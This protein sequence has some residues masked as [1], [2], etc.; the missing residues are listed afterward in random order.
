MI[1]LTDPVSE[2]EEDFHR[3]EFYGDEGTHLATIE[4]DGIEDDKGGLWCEVAVWVRV[5]S[6]N[7]RP[8]I[9]FEKVNLLTKAGNTGAMLNRLI[10]TDAGSVNW[11]QGFTDAVGLT[12][13]AFRTQSSEGDW[14]EKGVRDGA[15]PYLLKPFILKSGVTLLFGKH[16]DGKSMLALRWGLGI[17]TGKGFG[18]ELPERTGPILYVDIEDT[19][20]PHELRMAA[21]QVSLNISDDEMSHL[22]WHERVSGNIKDARRRLKRLVRDKGFALVII[23]SVGLAR[24]G[25]VSAS[26]PTIKLF[27]LF[28]QLGV[29]VLALDHVTK[30]D[31][32]RSS[33]GNMDHREATPIG[34]QFTQS[35]AR[36]AWYIQVLPQS[37]A[38][39][40]KL[41]LFNTK[42]NHTPQHVPIGLSTKLD[43]DEHHNIT[44]VYHKVD[45]SAHD[46]IV[47]SEM[48][49]HK[50]QKLLLWHFKQQ[51]EGGHVI[52]MTLTEMT[53]GSG[54]NGSTL[55]GI[56]TEKQAMWWEQLPKSKQYILSPE[57]METAMLYDSWNLPSGTELGTNPGT[58]QEG[59]DA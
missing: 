19:K 25:D 20:E 37:T 4:F 29:P 50:H 51:R 1:P 33:T 17:A 59:K 44:E 36:L 7:D 52:P 48:Q 35:S 56:V 34:S 9:S 11:E 2:Y 14:M 38:K 39:L 47:A 32:K 12:V 6:S 42:H 26:E 28:N 40:K 57:G 3:H 23:D 43:W 46:E 22:V 54:V 8:L 30:E 41:N 55:R 13:T 18:G 27:K 5:G 58:D 45:G 15:T 53:K 16:G 24:G 31:G 10:K 49:L 21:M